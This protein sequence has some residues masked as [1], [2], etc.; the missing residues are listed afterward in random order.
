M[1]IQITVYFVSL[2]LLIELYFLFIGHLHV[3]LYS[4]INEWLVK[5]MKGIIHLL[6]N[7]GK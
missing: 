1:S 4:I 3:Q 7:E 5:Y 2:C 6:S